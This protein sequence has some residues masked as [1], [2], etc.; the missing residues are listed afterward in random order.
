MTASDITERARSWAAQLR[1]A[2]GGIGLPGHVAWRLA[3][4]ADP[5]E[6]GYVDVLIPAQPGSRV[7]VKLLII[8][9][10]TIITGACEQLALGRPPEYGETTTTIAVRPISDVTVL[11]AAGMDQDWSP[12]NSDNIRI[13][14]GAIEVQ[15]ADGTMLALPQ[16][17]RADHVD[18]AIGLLRDGMLQH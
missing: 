9:E 1:S 3:M 12:R 5:I 16:S 7:D 18:T 13:G 15:L 8:T 2:S 10:T 6:A 11:R 14:D 4:L 17:S